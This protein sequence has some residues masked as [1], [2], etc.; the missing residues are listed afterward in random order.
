M[1]QKEINKDIGYLQVI[2]S[3]HNTYN[4]DGR[5]GL[6]VKLVTASYSSI[7]LRTLEGILKKDYMPEVSD[8]TVDSFGRI[9]F[10]FECLEKDEMQ[11]LNSLE[12]AVGENKKAV[13]EIDF[14]SI[15]IKRWIEFDIFD[16]LPIE[17]IQGLKSIK[18]GQDEERIPKT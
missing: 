9:V 16:A 2:Q 11:S 18:K 17:I 4:W 8:I 7:L 3:L 1:A 14:R 6:P 15:E 5:G 13:A 10:L 12:L